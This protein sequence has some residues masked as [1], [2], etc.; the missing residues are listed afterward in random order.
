MI[1]RDSARKRDG[2]ERKEDATMPFWTKCSSRRERKPDEN[3]NHHN[4]NIA[5][6]ASY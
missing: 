4:N 3:K 6:D 1:S 5:N 2:D